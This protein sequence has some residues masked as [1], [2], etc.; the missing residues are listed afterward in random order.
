MVKPARIQSKPQIEHP[1]R[2]R[3]NPHARTHTPSALYYYPLWQDNDS[4]SAVPSFVS[5]QAKY[6]YHSIR[7]LLLYQREKPTHV[8]KAYKNPQKQNAAM[9]IRNANCSTIALSESTMSESLNVTNA[10][11][12]VCVCVCAVR[13]CCINHFICESK[14]KNAS[15]PWEHQARDQRQNVDAERARPTICFHPKQSTIHISTLRI[16][17]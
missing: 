2:Y 14:E 16:K 8:H 5:T 10:S 3:P 13:V 4:P 15:I 7:R 9:N 12:R 6:T 17:R 1:P 11:L